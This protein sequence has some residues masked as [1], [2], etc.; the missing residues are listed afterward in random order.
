MVLRPHPPQSTYASIE[1]DGAGRIRRFAGRWSDAPERLGGLRGYVF[2]GV[3]VLEPEILDHLPPAG[4]SCINAD[5]Y[6]H[7]LEAGRPAVGWV[8][9]GAW[10]EPSTPGRYLDAVG[11]VLRGEVPFGRFVAGGL[12]PFAGAV[13]REAGVWVHEGAEVARSATLEA[14]VFV[15]P[16]AVVGAGAHL[17][18]E[19][20]VEAGG[21]VA[22]GARLK[23][24]VV[25]PHA[26]VRGDEALVDTV[27]VDATRRVARGDHSK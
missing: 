14:P 24:S 12:A 22:P 9:S 25:L 4:A 17:G 23:R 7:L 15:G 2:T 13:E 16:E 18:P 6:V 26:R 21:Q 19:V 10:F 1:I 5:G 3:H 8:T 27:V 11:A 20:S